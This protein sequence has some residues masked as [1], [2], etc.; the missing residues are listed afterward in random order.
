MTTNSLGKNFLIV[1]LIVAVGA[2]SYSILNAPDK[3]D[4]GEKISDAIDELPN[5]ADKAARQLE[6]RTPGDKLKDAASDA[7]DDL[8]KAT[9]QE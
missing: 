3:R 7:R 9:N 8:K 4:A 5:G 1:A 6:D 2:V